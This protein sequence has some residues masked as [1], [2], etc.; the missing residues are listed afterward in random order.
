VTPDNG[1]PVEIGCIPT[2]QALCRVNCAPGELGPSKL[3]PIVGHPLLED[4]SGVAATGGMRLRVVPCSFAQPSS[5]R[6]SGQSARAA[7]SDRIKLAQTVQAFA[8]MTS[9]DLATVLL[10]FWRRDRRIAK[11]GETIGMLTLHFWS[12]CTCTLH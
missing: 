7:E 12:R 5:R 10:G 4:S 8:P 9:E 6:M 11:R 3:K 2:Q 1:D